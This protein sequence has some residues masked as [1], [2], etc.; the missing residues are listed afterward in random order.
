MA[1]KFNFRKLENTT[2][3]G[4]PAQNIGC[5]LECEYCCK[6]S[7]CASKTDCNQTLLIFLI[8]LGCLLF[9]FSIC[10]LIKCIFS[11]TKVKSLLS[12][13]FELRKSEEEIKEMDK[14]SEPGRIG[15]TY[16]D[17]NT[18]LNHNL[19]SLRGNNFKFGQNNSRKD[20]SKYAT[21]KGR[22]IDSEELK[23]SKMPSAD[24]DLKEEDSREL[25]RKKD[26][27]KGRRSRRIKKIPENTINELK[28]SNE[29]NENFSKIKAFE[30]PEDY[31]KKKRKRNSGTIHLDSENFNFSSEYKYTKENLESRIGKEFINDL[32]ENG[33]SL[34]IGIGG[35]VAK[36]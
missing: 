18:L 8:I 4:I 31:Q 1:K 20:Y 13:W 33:E 19:H 5:E 32:P 6:N 3:E 12:Q 36:K 21:F 7:V 25:V 29:E 15:L 22:K 30:L 17:H 10:L 35:K 23:L 28:P 16:D 26:S 2:E 11:H 27:R 24:T 34:M 9:I 14:P